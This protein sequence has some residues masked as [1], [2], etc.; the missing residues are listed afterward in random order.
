MSMSSSN[1]LSVVLNAAICVGVLDQ[2]TTE[3]LS[4]EVHLLPVASH[5][6]NSQCTVRDREVMCSKNGF[7]V[8]DRADGV[9][10]LAAVV[11]CGY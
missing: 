3:I 8:V 9:T 11:T 5:N 10:M 7:V 1:E 4:T 6:V 2:D